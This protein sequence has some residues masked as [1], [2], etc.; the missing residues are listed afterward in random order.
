MF[1]AV[2]FVRVSGGFDF[3]RGVLPECTAVTSEYTAFSPSNLRWAL[4]YLQANGVVNG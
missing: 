3:L 2:F 1:I 4:N